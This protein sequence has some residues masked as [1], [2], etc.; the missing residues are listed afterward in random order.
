MTEALVPEVRDLVCVADRMCVVDRVCGEMD[1]VPVDIQERRHERKR[2]RSRRR[3]TGGEHADG[4]RDDRERRQQIDPVAG[5]P[6]QRR[7][8]MEE[9]DGRDEPEERAL[10]RERPTSEQ[11][12]PH[13]AFGRRAAGSAPS[14]STRDRTGGARG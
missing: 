4:G 8:V 7:Q 6:A 1:A 12:R 14:R 3:D 11:R 2:D 13:G 9:E 5:R 10:G